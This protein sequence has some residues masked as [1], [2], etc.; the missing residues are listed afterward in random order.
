[1]ANAC[2]QYID[3]RNLQFRIALQER[4]NEEAE[5]KERLEAERQK[6]LEKQ[7]KAGKGKEEEENEEAPPEEQKKEEEGG[8]DEE[9]AKTLKANMLYY[10]SDYPTTKEEYLALSQEGFII[11]SNYSISEKFVQEEI[12]EEE[13]PPEQA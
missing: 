11:H 9:E 3:D 5:E 8:D 6:E 7:K 4:L 12:E 10:F 2:K 1:M 13:Q